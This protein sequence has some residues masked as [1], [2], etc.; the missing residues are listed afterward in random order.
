MTKREILFRLLSYMRR[1]RRQFVIATI[2]LLVAAVAEVTGPYLV[3]IFLDNYVAKDHYPAVIM[4]ALA[5]GYIVST[6]VSAGFQ[7]QYELRFN[8]MAVAI[9]Q[10]IRKAVFANVIKQPLSAF[11]YVP[12][13]RIVSRL[14]NDTE[15][16]KELYV[17]VL[18]TFLRN[19]ALIGVM[20]VAML[21]LS[22]QLT[23]VVLVLLPCVVLVMARYQKRSAPAYRRA[24]DRLADING[25][26]NESVLGMNLIQLMQQ[27]RAFSSR[28]SDMTADHLDAMVTIQRL[29]G[30]YLRPLIDLLAGAALLS[31]VAIFGFSGTA[32]IGVG[33]LYAFLSY[34]GRITEPLIEMMQQL[35]LLQQ[36][37]S[38]GERLFEM[39]DTPPE[40]YGHDTTP[41]PD[42]AIALQNVSFSYDG[43]T[44]VLSDVNVDVPAGGFLALVGHTGSGKSTLASLLM[45]FYRTG[46]GTL[47][48]GG[49]PIESLS[50]QTLREGVAMVQQDPHM[51]TGSLRENIALG[52]TL[53][54][55]KI[56]HALEQV[57]LADYVKGLPA[58][59]DTL[60]GEG[61]MTFSAGQ[62]QLLALA[63]V[64]VRQPKI[65]IL[66]E[67]TANIDSGTEELVQ[68]AL[69]RLRQQMTVVVIAHR[70]S[71]IAEAD[72]ILVLHRGRV[73]EQG[74]HQSL[75]RQQGRYWQ[76]YQL[77]QASAHLAALEEEAQV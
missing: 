67:A 48:L 41:I 12:M 13:G 56:W 28:F 40:Q 49:L 42:G 44:P 51:L 39:M 6:I 60:L 77:Q 35:S 38:A 61:G 11:D 66:D 52:Q 24:R 34:L 63:R 17:S 53:D 58:G 32:V 3:Q 15:S 20:L 75:L 22:V 10:R 50:H 21:M 45:G 70:L 59:L 33:V 46:E 69:N 14:T 26:M 73:I 5:V 16:L 19:I 7:Y 25:V 64:L 30:I 65:L 57:A 2:F 43:E 31:L 68:Q 18:S 76:M 72:N 55:E 27:E 23:M 8:T 47:T 74:R 54:D 1:D 71:T 9:I 36:A 37:I 29:N 4:W 62:R